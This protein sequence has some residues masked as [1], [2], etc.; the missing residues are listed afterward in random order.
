MELQSGRFIF[1]GRIPA[2]NEVIAYLGL[3]SN[4]GRREEKL[5]EAQAQLHCPPE[6]SVLRS[7]S[8]YETEPVGIKDQPDFLNSALEIQTSLSPQALLKRILQTEKKMG[9]IRTERWG[10]RVIDID[11]LLY[12]E[13]E[14]N[15]PD[16]IVPHPLLKERAFALIP[17]AEIAPKARFPGGD[18]VE[19]KLEKL[20]YLRNNLRVK[21]VK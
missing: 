7:S 8:F 17:L 16:L 10:P 18:T 15:E 12:D 13:L 6:I 4:L 5:A 11:L 14:V 9:R 20:I 19:N 1:P 3:G 21:V 2:M